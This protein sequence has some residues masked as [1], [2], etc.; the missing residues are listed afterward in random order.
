[1]DTVQ[2]LKSGSSAVDDA[3]GAAGQ[4]NRPGPPLALKF[5][6]RE[7]RGGLSGFYIF[8]ACIMLGVGAI[9]GVNSVGASI[10]KG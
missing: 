4:N 7:M 10:S 6:I 2:N 5:A 9:A 3:S 8:L 1:M